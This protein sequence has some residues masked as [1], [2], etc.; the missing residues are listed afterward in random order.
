MQPRPPPVR[1]DTL[2]LANRAA[3]LEAR[4]AFA[5]AIEAWTRAVERDPAFLPAQL[6]LA[7]ARIRAGMPADALALLHWAIA[8][9]R[10]A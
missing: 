8:Q 2:A 9:E 7:Q 3:A 4:G 5:E 1:P 6:G 10:S